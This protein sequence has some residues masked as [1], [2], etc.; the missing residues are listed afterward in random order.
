M[1][2]EPEYQ[3]I[4]ITIKKR[5]TRRE[6]ETHNEYV[7]RRAKERYNNDPEFVAK[8]KLKY[9]KKKNSLS[10]DPE[11]KRLLTADKSDIVN[12]RNIKIYV[13]TNKINNLKCT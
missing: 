1:T 10:D 11:Y 13:A 9:Y 2:I 6:G 5:G 3:T 4:T 12:L 8:S 7:K